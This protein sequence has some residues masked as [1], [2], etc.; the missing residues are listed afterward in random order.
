MHFAT[1]ALRVGQ[2]PDPQYR[3]VIPPLFQS[4]TFA[5]TS[6]DDIPPIDY[7]RCQNPNRQSLEQ[8]IAALENGRHCTVFA[9]GMAAIGSTFGLLQQGDHLLMATD[10]YGGTFRLGEQWLPKWGVSV[11]EFCPHDPGSI[12]E[13]VQPNTKMLIFETPA[14]PNLR[15]CDI[16]AV[17]RAAK[18]HGLITVFD[19]TFASPA[20]QNPLDLGADIVVHSTTKYIAGHSDVIGGAV[21]TNDDALA[22]H[23]FEYAK[24]WGGVPSPFDCWLTLRGVKTLDVRMQRHSENALAVARYLAS[25]PKVARVH[26]P[27]LEDHSDHGVAARQMRSFGGMLAVEFHT[28]E[29]ARQVA[30]STRLFIL[31]ESLGGVESLVAYPPL[32]SHATMSEPQRLVRG[33]P[34]TMLRL[35]VGIE[36]AD[37]LVADLAA[38]IG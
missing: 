17:T 25:H 27:G 6:L 1:R 20:L 5:W 35:S 36:H 18:A 2:S 33:I 26:Y 7:T 32:M 8:V 14:N 23:T 30:E 29:H 31:A 4:S 38:A 11:S 16:A 10:I 12:A 15:V 34:P 24:A 21:I 22:H 28:V 3:A 9:S 19:N 13:A 37:D